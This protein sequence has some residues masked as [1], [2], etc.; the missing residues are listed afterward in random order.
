[1]TRIARHGM[2][3][4]PDPEGRWRTDLAKASARDSH[5]PILEDCPCPACA[6]GYSRAYLHHLLRARELTALRLITLHNL[7]FVARLMADLRT[8]IAAGTLAETAAALRAGAGPGGAGLG[9]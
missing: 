2:A 1:P 5:E 3:L 7:S 6:G 8:A 9:D 4:V